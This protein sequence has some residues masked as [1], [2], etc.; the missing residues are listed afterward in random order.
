[1]ANQGMVTFTSNGNVVMKVVVGFEGMLAKKVAERLKSEWPLTAKEAWTI[2]SEERFGNYETLVVV[3]EDEMFYEGKIM[4]NELT[5]Y[6][7]TF[8]KPD[9]NPRMDNGETDYYEH[10]EV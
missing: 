2:A 4:K 3:T 8:H 5:F 10:V 6:R 7:K 1:M 9:F